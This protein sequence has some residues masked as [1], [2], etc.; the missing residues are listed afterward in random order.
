METLEEFHNLVASYP[1]LL[2]EIHSIWAIPENQV[3]GSVNEYTI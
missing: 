2:S 3:M 1:P